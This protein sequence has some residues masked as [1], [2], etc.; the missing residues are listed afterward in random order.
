MAKKNKDKKTKGKQEE[1]VIAK[2]GKMQPLEVLGKTE[3]E[4]SSQNQNKQME[5]KFY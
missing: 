1:L 4:T 3:A 5:K 2:D